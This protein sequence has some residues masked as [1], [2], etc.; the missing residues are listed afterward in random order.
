MVVALAPPDSR[1]EVYLRFS[2][3]YALGPDTLPPTLLVHAGNDIIVPVEQSHIT[4][5]ELSRLGTPHDFL[6]YPNIEHYLDT[7][8]RDPTQI[9]MLNKTLEFLA[10]HARQ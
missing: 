2:P 1:P 7:S 9:D 5:R 8:K 6:L 4:D 3:H 10:E